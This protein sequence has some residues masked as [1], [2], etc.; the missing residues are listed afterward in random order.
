MNMMVLRQAAQLSCILKMHKR[1]PKHTLKNIL[2]FIGL[3]P[4]GYPRSDCFTGKRKTR[5]QSIK[6]RVDLAKRNVSHIVVSRT[7]N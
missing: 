4:R 3:W 1:E 6:K 7:I 2:W 5:M